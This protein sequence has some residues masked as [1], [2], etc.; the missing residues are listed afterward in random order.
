MHDCK[1]KFFTASWNEMVE[2][3]KTM[4]PEP[5]IPGIGQRPT[6]EKLVSQWYIEMI[7]HITTTILRP[8]AA[9]DI[10]RTFL[11]ENHKVK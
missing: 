10:Q 3:S 4:P 7:K 1:P 8:T 9:I 6:I 2:S 5:N 11:Q